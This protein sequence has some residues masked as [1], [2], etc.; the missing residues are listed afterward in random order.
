[1]IKGGGR[2]RTFEA[3]TILREV[4]G[5]HAERV[6]GLGVRRMRKQNLCTPQTPCRDGR[7]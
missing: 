6:R 4:Q 1:M 7:V 2:L 5:L 3:A